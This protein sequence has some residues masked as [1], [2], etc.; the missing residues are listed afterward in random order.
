MPS[1]LRL[2]SLLRSGT[3]PETRRLAIQSV[4]SGAVGAAARRIR[5]DRIGLLRDLGDPSAAP[6]RVRT[7]IGHPATREL[8]GASLLF[9][10]ARYIVP[11]GWATAWAA[12]RLRRHR[13]SG[14]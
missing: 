2:A 8:A 4:R 10:P 1:P 11:I 7:V 13:V 5:H 12:G 3:F 6:G 9:L 14:P